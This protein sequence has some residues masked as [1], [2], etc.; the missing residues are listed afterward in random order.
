M[1]YNV[2]LISADEFNIEKGDS[3]A[4]LTQ[5]KPS[6]KTI[7]YSLTS[8]SDV[9]SIDGNKVIGNK[10]GTAMITATTSDRKNKATT[11]INVG[12]LKY[13]LT[14]KRTIKDIVVA[15]YP[16]QMVLGDEYVCQ[17]FN[18]SDITEEHPWKYGL[19]DDNLNYFTSSNDS[20]ISVKNGCLFAKDIGTA[21]ITVQDIDNTVSKSFD[22]EVIT[23]DTTY[24]VTYY[25]DN[26]KLD[27]ST[28]ETTTVSLQNLMTEITE[29]GYDHIIFP[30]NSV[31][32]IS[33]VYGSI[34]FPSHVLLDFNNSVLQIQPSEMTDKG[35]TMLIFKNTDHT[36]VKNAKIYG[37]RYLTDSIGSEGCMS[38]LWSGK[39][40]RSGCINCEISNSPGFN[41]GPNSSFK[42]CQFG[43][44]NIESGGLDDLGNNID[45]EY[46]FRAINYIDI[47]KLNS[48]IM[49]GN[50][51]GYQNYA[52]LIARL[53]DIWFFD[54]DKKL[55]KKLN[56]CVQFY[57]YEKPENAKYCKIVFYQKTKPTSQDA[58]Y[59]SVAHIYDQNE[60]EK[61]F[62]KKC[63][64]ANNHATG[65]A[66][67]AGYDWV[68]DN[69]IFENNG[70][71][72]STAN[73]DWEDGWNQNQG[74]VLKNCIFKGSRVLSIQTVCCAIHNNTFI[75]ASLGIEH[76]TEF[77]RV[78]LNTFQGVGQSIS[79]MSKTDAVFSQNQGTNNTKYDLKVDGENLDYAIRETENIFN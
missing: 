43:L 72:S 28:V 9:V 38:V 24:D 60:P 40:Y 65:L 8:D 58:D 12:K 76:R 30:E 56:N 57:K 41:M 13:N 68:F 19:L 6:F 1:W 33:P 78:W 31:Y 29:N 14:Q 47:S 62:I 55:I 71:R 75:N 54:S 21:T 77:S 16:K 5:I 66:P 22:V 49:F 79:F 32:N 48:P 42:L 59:S 69:C 74:H 67:N 44:S 23:D 37:E 51:L 34:Y 27:L 61:C 10:I 70:G 2:F 45:E 50:R 63:K 53:Y 64:I 15:R 3:L 52:Y 18:L 46:A 17:A 73:I 36:I 7:S 20:I 39:N 35:Y 26:S 11:N 4:V 25:V